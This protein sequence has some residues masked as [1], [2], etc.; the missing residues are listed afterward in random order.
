MP[1]LVPP[2][3]MAGVLVVLLPVFVLMTLDRVKKQGAFIRERFL[4]T[5]CHGKDHCPFRCCHGG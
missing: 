2:L 4:I 3:V 1:G 5:G